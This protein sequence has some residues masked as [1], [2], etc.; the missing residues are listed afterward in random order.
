M[1]LIC[2]DTD[3]VLADLDDNN[4]RVGECGVT[5]KEE[6]GDQL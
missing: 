1:N 3:A 6:E 4:V 5:I 2:V